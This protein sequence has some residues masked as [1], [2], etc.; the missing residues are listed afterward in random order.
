MVRST[1]R[2]AGS[3]AELRLTAR[4]TAA[5]GSPSVALRALLESLSGSI[6]SSP[7][8]NAA[9]ASRLLLAI[10][11]LCG[12]AALLTFLLGIGGPSLWIDEGHSWRYADEPLG[13][14]LA[15]TIGSTNAVEAA[16]YAFLHVWIAVAGSSEVALRLPSALAMAIGVWAASKTAADI[17]GKQA[18]AVAGFVMLVLPG[19]S[20]YAQEARPYALAV[21]AVSISTFALERG[22]MSD[23]RRWWAAYAASLVAVG[24]LHL[25]SLLVVSGQAVAMLLIAPR[26]WR[27]FVTTVASAVVVVLPVA[28]LGFRQRG[29][30]SWI[31]PVDL[32]SL[33][34]GPSELT[35]SI[36]V[37]ACLVVLVLA[38]G[39]DRRLL[40][41][42]LPT[43]LA[44]PIVLWVLSN[45][46][47]LYLGRYLV[48]AVPGFALAVAASTVMWTA[49]GVVIAVLLLALVL[50]Q[51]MAIRGPAGHGQDYRAAAR[52]VATDCRARISYDVM[53]RDA[54]VYYLQR[55]QACS[56]SET[57]T[58]DHLWVVQ[59]AG[60]QVLEPGYA[61]V[62]A[63]KFGS[64]IVTYWV[65][66]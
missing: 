18:S 61:L 50:P 44:T 52:L 8:R 51:Q 5:A 1:R 10:P 56:P 11:T 63:T 33:W 23:R 34:T 66:T 37:T 19:V 55:Q 21:A 57:A 27:G 48:G 25:L 15:T 64:A 65:A 16:Y 24:W 62:R 49:R 45:V 2:S 31:P 54:M 42:G 36:A 29:Q 4:K 35:G 12:L 22:L 17:A 26:R 7:G 30:I 9:P 39:R 38:S 28:V 58:A 60:P 59:A 3:S 32:A 6:T 47:P 46:E 40:A 20:R 41:L 53:S 14:M 13:V 43:A